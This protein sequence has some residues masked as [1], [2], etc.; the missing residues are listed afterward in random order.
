M[1]TEDVQRALKTIDE[2]EARERVAAG[3][4]SDLQGFDLTDEERELI[5]EAAGDYPEVAGF[6]FDA[7]L[8]AGDT[9]Q[10]PVDDPGGGFLA[11]V[12]GQKK[13][14]N[15]VLKRGADTNR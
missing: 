6:S 2:P 11:K 9:F 7:F 14:N 3:D 12:S 13:Y 5:E 10:F 1:S 8:G 15:I 4:L